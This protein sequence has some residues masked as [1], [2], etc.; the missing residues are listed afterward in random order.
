[1]KMQVDLICIGDELLSGLVEDTNGG[2]ISR[3]LLSVGAMTRRRSVV[4]DDAEAIE[5]ALQEGMQH[6]D[7]V[8]CCGGLGPTDDD[9]TREAAAGALNRNLYLHEGWLS[10]LEHFFCT[11]GYAMPPANRKQALLIEGSELIDNPLGTAPGIKVE[12]G[13]Q[14]LILLPGPPNELRPMFENSILPLIKGRVYGRVMMLKTLRCA[15]LGE[16]LLEEK[17]KS[18]GNLAGPAVSLVARGMEVDLHLKVNAEIE[19]AQVIL[20]EATEKLRGVLQGY[21]YAEG[22]TSLA[23]T[24]ADLL[25]RQGQTLALAES[26]SGGLLADSITDIPGSSEFFKGCAVTYDLQSKNLLP[27]VDQGM[28]REQGAVSAVIAESMARGAKELFNADIGVGITGVAGPGSDISGRPAGLVYVAV[29]S[30][31][32]IECRE[33]KF[34]GNRRA[35]KER[36]AQSALIMLWKM[37]L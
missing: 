35:V 2:Y 11:R 15:G 29:A 33:L 28:L 6:S 16:S 18:S 37:L 10:R 34:I 24:V 23:K 3:R 30:D 32:E 20:T 8:I 25:T 7:A 31:K 1:M 22:E 4:A 9:L 26:C 13:K 36:A 19:K 17:I 21:L 27:G 12:I 14:L 5:A